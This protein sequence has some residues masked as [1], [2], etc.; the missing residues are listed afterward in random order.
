V[1]LVKS[2]L[3][4]CHRASTDAEA[5]GVRLR[6]DASA[7]VGELA[8]KSIGLRR[9]AR[10][11]CAVAAVRVATGGADAAAVAAIAADEARWR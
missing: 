2:A 10:A 8:A 4:A 9:T 6:G 7:A 1:D 3:G 5:V 11:A